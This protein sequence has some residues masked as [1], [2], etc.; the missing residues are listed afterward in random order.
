MQW[1][2]NLEV[3]NCSLFMNRKDENLT[4]LIELK[5]TDAFFLLKISRSQFLN[6]PRKFLNPERKF[7]KDGDLLLVLKILEIFPQIVEW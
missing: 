1:K 4:K 3:M 6:K 2:G 5:S 7:L